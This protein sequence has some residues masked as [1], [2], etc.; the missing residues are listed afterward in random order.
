MPKKLDSLSRRMIKSMMPEL[1]RTCRACKFALMLKAI[2][3]TWPS[4]AAMRILIFQLSLNL[5]RIQRLTFLV[6]AMI[7]A[8]SV[9]STLLEGKSGAWTLSQIKLLSNLSLK[10]LWSFTITCSHL[11]TTVLEETQLNGL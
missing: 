8:R 4:K 2:N 5:I 3:K 10:S 7:R 9:C 6:E 1:R 11:L